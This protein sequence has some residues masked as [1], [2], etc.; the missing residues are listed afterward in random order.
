MEATGE[1][2]KTHSHT[3]SERWMRVVVV[4]LLLVLVFGVRPPPSSSFVKPLKIDERT[5]ERKGKKCDGAQ[6]EK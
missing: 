4:V 3:V 5:K 2:V 1:G 6:K